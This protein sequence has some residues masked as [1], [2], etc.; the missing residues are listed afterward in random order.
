[1]RIRMQAHEE[2]EAQRRRKEEMLQDIEDRRARVA[3]DKQY[4]NQ[5]RI[6]SVR[7]HEGEIQVS[8]SNYPILIYRD[9]LET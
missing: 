4:V 1:M 5:G 3:K 2:R 9:L 8:N 7:R 6:R